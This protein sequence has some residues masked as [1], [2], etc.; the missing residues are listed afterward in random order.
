MMVDDDLVILKIGRHIL[1][2][3]YEVYPIPSAAKLFE[4]LNVITPDLILLDVYM[5]ETDGIEAIKRLKADNRYARIPVIF[6]TSVDDDKSVFEHLK[7]GAYSHMAKPFSADELLTRVENCL[8]DYFP[9]EPPT[10]EEEEAKQVILAVDDAPDVLRM[11]HLLLRETYKV[12]T[13]SE[14]EKLE[15]ILVTITPDFFLLDCTMPVRSGFDLIPIIRSHQQHKDT[16]IMFL[17]S[18]TSPGYMTEARRLGTV[19]YILKPIKIDLL[20]DKI[21][22]HIKKK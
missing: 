21:A 12:Y 14:P 9:A 3:M 2:E 10:A 11:V 15:D 20:R 18:E 22:E 16:P 19:D 6:V 8:N 4:M 5:P 17:T 7:L 1:K 13:L